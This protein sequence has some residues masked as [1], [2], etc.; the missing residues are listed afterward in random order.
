MEHTESS[1]DKLFYILANGQLIP[2]PCLNFSNTR[3]G[4]IKQWFAVNHGINSENQEYIFNGVTLQD[5][6][7]LTQV[8][9]T[10]QSTI[11]LQN[12]T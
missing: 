1:F 9:I 3:I 2:V 11:R 7:T 5:H 10:A 6:L 4:D 8:G 12:L